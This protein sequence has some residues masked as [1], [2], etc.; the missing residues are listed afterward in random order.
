MR[1]NSKSTI[2]FMTAAQFKSIRQSIN[3]NYACEAVECIPDNISTQRTTITDQ[4]SKEKNLQTTRYNNEDRV[5]KRLLSYVKKYKVHK[6]NLIK[7]HE[8][9]LKEEIHPPRINNK[10]IIRSKEV[11]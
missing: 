2:G 3:N 6:E 11:Y 10:S 7:E 9:K 4:I 8:M 1:N 5:E